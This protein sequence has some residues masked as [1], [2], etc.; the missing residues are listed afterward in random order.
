M[1]FKNLTPHDVNV[2]TANGFIVRIPKSE[3]APTRLK[4]VD[5]NPFDVNGV[6]CVVRQYEQDNLPKQEEGILLIVSQM[7]AAANPMRRD[8]FYPGDMKRDLEGRIIVGIDA[9][10]LQLCQVPEPVSSQ[11]DI[12]YA[13]RHGDFSHRR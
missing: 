1:Q 5:V 4:Q 6:P 13:E 8:L 2:E 9:R 3:G 10:C 12:E 7:V 11:G